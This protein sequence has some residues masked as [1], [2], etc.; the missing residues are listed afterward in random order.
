MCGPAGVLYPRAG[1]LG[2]CTA[3]NALIFPVSLND[4]DWD[5]IADLTGDPSWTATRM[6]AYAKRIEQCRHRPLW[7]VARRFGVDPT[8]RP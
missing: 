6:Q 3:H 1:T 4:E 2:G 5:H 8:M 7:N